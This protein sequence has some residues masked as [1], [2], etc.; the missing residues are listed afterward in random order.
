MLAPTQVVLWSFAPKY[1]TQGAQYLLYKTAITRPQ[2]AT[3][4]THYRRIFTAVILLL[5]LCAVY[6]ADRAMGKNYYSVLK[7]TTSADDKLLK[8]NYRKMSLQY[9]PD[10]LAGGQSVLDSEIYL[11]IREAYDVLKD[12]ISRGVYGNAFLM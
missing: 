11:K 2:P 7:C 4:H 10:K 12:P 9:H 6:D 8:I 3:Q 5:L 1:I